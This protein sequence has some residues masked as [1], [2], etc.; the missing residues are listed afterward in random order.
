MLTADCWCHFINCHRERWDR[1]AAAAAF[2]Y[3]LAKQICRF[4]LTPFCS[5]VQPVQRKVLK[6]CFLTFLLTISQEHT[7]QL[8][9]RIQVNMFSNRL[10]TLCSTWQCFN[11]TRFTFHQLHYLPFY[12]PYFVVRTRRRLKANCS[13]CACLK[14]FLNVLRDLFVLLLLLLLLLI[15]QLK[16]SQAKCVKYFMQNASW[17]AASV[18][19]TQLPKPVSVVGL[20]CFS[21]LSAMV[22]S[23]ATL[24]LK[25]E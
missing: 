6:C 22:E 23:S 24:S 11:S 17:L 4:L 5:T 9:T 7:S 13:L 14:Y 8:L 3:P 19:H 18:A 21:K 12:V 25:H 1:A 15:Q 2:T 10:C 16:A 20:L